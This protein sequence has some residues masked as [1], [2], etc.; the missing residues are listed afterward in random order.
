M[1]VYSCCSTHQQ[2][3]V[4]TAAVT[5]AYGELCCEQIDAVEVL[6]LMLKLT[7]LMQ[8]LQDV[9]ETPGYTS[10]HIKHIVFHVTVMYTIPRVRWS[11]ERLMEA[12]CNKV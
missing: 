7:R 5:I 1:Q 8:G 3:T 2:A 6:N 12:V 4:I 11:D 9:V 10:K